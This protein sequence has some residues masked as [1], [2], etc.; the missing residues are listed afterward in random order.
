MAQTSQVAARALIGERSHKIA[1][2]RQSLSRFRVARAHYDRP[3]TQY[4]SRD[5]I[6]TTS[7][8]FSSKSRLSGQSQAEESSAW[9]GIVSSRPASTT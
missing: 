6:A 1:T 2:P 9:R 5:A 3:P 8:N 7:G 4:T